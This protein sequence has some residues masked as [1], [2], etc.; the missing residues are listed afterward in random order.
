MARHG[1]GSSNS[2]CRKGDSGSSN[3][4]SEYESNREEGPGRVLESIFADKKHEPDFH[5]SRRVQVVRNDGFVVLVLRVG[6]DR[7]N[8]STEDVYEAILDHVREPKKFCIKTHGT[9]ARRVRVFSRSWITASVSESDYVMVSARVRRGTTYEING[10]MTANARG[11][12]PGYLYVSMLCAR[13]RRDGAARS[14]L[15]MADRVAR[16]LKLS[17]VALTPASDDVVGLYE[18]FGY[19]W[20]NSGELMVK[21]VAAN[22]VVK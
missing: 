6:E 20:E 7:M 18:K 13:T 11:G 22:G 8:N 2:E 3:S 19:A 15:T 17:L 14:L 4:N 5:P 9:R 10:V 12:N 1:D 21:I 16:R